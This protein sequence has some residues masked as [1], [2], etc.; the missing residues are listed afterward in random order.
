MDENR[1]EEEDVSHE[2]RRR[3]D[4]TLRQVR[5]R[6]NTRPHHTRPDSFDIDSTTRTLSSSLSVVDDHTEWRAN[7]VDQGTDEMN[8][9]QEQ[10]S[11]G[12]VGNFSLIFISANGS[13]TGKIKGAH[14]GIVSLS[15]PPEL[16]CYLLFFYRINGNNSGNSCVDA[17]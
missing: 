8:M 9:D 11:K 2:L 3:G 5:H 13:T 14:L 6:R 15:W 10:K 17:M 16:F 1:W 7:I 4:T 12:V